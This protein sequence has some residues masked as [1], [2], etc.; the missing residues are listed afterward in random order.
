M[1]YPLK[2]LA[3]RILPYLLW[4]SIFLLPWQLRHTIIF[5][6]AGGYFFEY[7]SI[8][9][10]LTDLVTLALLVCWTI[11]GIRRP[12]LPLWPLGLWLVWILLTALW[13][14]DLWVSLWQGAHF[15]LYAGWFIYLISEVRDVQTI[16]WPFIWG[17]GLEAVVG[18]TQVALNHS[19][20]LKM[21]GESVLDPTQGGISVVEIQGQRFLRAYGLTPHPNVFAGLMVTGLTLIS[22]L[23]VSAKE[24]KNWLLGLAVLLAAGLV[25]G[26]SRMAWVGGLGLVIYLLL[27]ASRQKSRAAV[28][29]A[30][31]IIAAAGL[32]L[33]S[34]QQ[35]VAT[36]FNPG[37]RLEEKSITEH[38]ESFKYYEK[39]VSTKILFVGGGIGSYPALLKE[40][41]PDQPGWWLQ[42]V[43][44][45]FL[46]VL[47]ETGVVGV[48]L[49]A[50]FLYALLIPL[51]R[52]APLALWIPMLLVLWLGALDHWP[53]SQAQ[54]RLLFFFALSLIVIKASNSQASSRASEDL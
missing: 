5:A 36:R 2:T 25:A 41:Y 30:G 16:I 20:G 48:A 34:H 21:L 24:R 26:F 50:W 52:K 40:K 7:G 46:L 17:V 15:L 42:P 13:A 38:V 8:H 3:A 47:A 44:D 9:L 51:I 35:M 37:A 54:G 23:A 43:H 39:T 27:V 28:T 1:P 19:L 14:P 49:L 10:Y 32:T 4:L 11:K 22:Y 12:A 33:F 29:L 18:L 53:W 45:T 31:V 6:Q